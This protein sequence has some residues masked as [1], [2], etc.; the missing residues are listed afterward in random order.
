MIS[1][2]LSTLLVLFTLFQQAPVSP[3]KPRQQQQGFRVSGVIVDAIGGQALAGAQVT[4][5]SQA[6][7]D[8]G[9]TVTT[10]DGG[11]F[12]FE[13]VWAGQ[14][15][16]YARRRGYVE[17]QYKQHGYLSTVIIAGPDLNTDNL[18]FEMLP[19]ASISGQILDEMGEPVRS[20]QVLLLQY[21]LRLGQRQKFQKRQQNT[22][23]QGHYHFGHLVPGA[24]FVGVVAEPWYAQHDGRQRR[25][26]V[27][28]DSAQT[29]DSGAATNANDP[30]D[31]VY[32]I[33]FFPNATDIDVASP[34]TLHPGDAEIADL[35]LQPVPAAH[36][37]FRSSTTDGPEQVSVQHIS[38]HIADGI[39]QTVPVRT[40]TWAPWAGSNIV[41]VN[42]L[43]P[44][45]LNV[46]WTW[47]KGNQSTDHARTLQ[48]GND[49]E[50]NPSDT[51]SSASVSGVATMDDGSALA[52]QARLGLRNASA[53]TAISVL[54]KPG[55]EFNF[56]GQNIDQGTYEV[57]MPQPSGALVRSISATGAKVSGHTIEI[58]SARDVRLTVVVSK[59]GGTV[60]G[61]A[62]K[63]GKPADGV[64]ILLVPQGP[65]P[66]ASLFRF[67]Q[68][69]SDGS[70]SLAR[71]LPGKY[72][73]VA[74]ENGWDLEWS[75]PGVSLK[76]LAGGQGI[77][78]SSDT[79]IKVSVN[80]QQ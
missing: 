23:D 37:T 52:P 24:Y 20:A 76:Y 61:L 3:Q 22:D 11:R 15:V 26:Q 49:L 42:G 40:T 50:I 51:A 10:G 6:A 74:I 17:Q 1:Q 68:S 80:V 72:T 58:G 46:T 70:F 35:R 77:Q 56:D 63:K 25:L 43:P 62:L 41:E 66:D 79:K 21:G 69:D 78:V 28:S 53:G 48:L 64:M 29:S 38:Q 45:R 12:S 73:V 36:L 47:S 27:D 71:V 33:V 39:E 2:L 9:Q 44:G 13:N 67:D 30:L 75:D 8:S 34:I 32:P 59:D 7:R 54:L 18:R 5:F 19:S 14:Y 57:G 16:L 60:T 4:L 65:E 31:V 55:G